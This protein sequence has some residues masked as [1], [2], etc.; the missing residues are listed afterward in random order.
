MQVDSHVKALPPDLWAC[1]HLTRLDLDLR[2]SAA[3][4]PAPSM[5]ALT[6]ALLPAVRELRLA[7]CQLPGGA[8]PPALCQLSGLQRLD[9]QRCALAS[10]CVHHGLPP[11]FS[12]LSCLVRRGCFT[13]PTWPAPGQA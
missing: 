13:L 6:A 12:R 5:P 11:Q 3:L 2:G 4:P 9:I 10:G 8:L 7:R 1:Q